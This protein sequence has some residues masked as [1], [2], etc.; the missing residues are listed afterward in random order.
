MYEII[1]SKE[2]KKQML[3]LDNQIQERI[4]IALEKLKFRPEARL[5]KLVGEDGFRLRVG[6][7]RV[8]VDI[9]RKKLFVLVLKVGHRKNVYGMG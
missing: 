4:F 6:N 5:K 8:I 2:A 1:F 3:K 7:Y 9:E